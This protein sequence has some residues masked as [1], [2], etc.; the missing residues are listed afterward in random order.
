MSPRWKKLVND[1]RLAK[2]RLFLML[3]ALFV[4]IFG[5]SLIFSSYTI[6]TRELDLNYLK[7]NPASAMLEVENL[8]SSLIEEVRNQPGI[9]DAEPTSWVSARIETREK[10]WI[11]LQLFV[12]ED[13]ESLRINKFW[14]QSGDWPPPEGSLLLERT[15]L[16]LLKASEGDQLTVQTPNGS[17]REILVS[18]VVHDPALTPASQEQRAYG[19]ITPSTLEW[20]GEENSLN[21]LKVTMT[22]SSFDAEVIEKKAVNLAGWLQGQGYTVEEIRIPPPGKHP[23]QSQVTGIQLMLFTFSILTLILSA[24]L[25]ATMI[26]GLLARQVREIGI[27]KAIGAQTRQIALPYLIL[28]AGMGFIA[29]LLGG[30]LGIK[31]GRGFAQIIADQLNFTLYSQSVSE[32]TY[33]LLFGFGILVPLLTAMIPISE[34]ARITVREAINDYENSRK[35]F[36]FHKLDRLFAKLKGVDRTLL[37]SLRNPFRKKGRLVLTLSLLTAAGGLFLTSLN[38]QSSWNALLSEAASNRHYDLEVRTSHLVSE[39]KMVSMISN[40][41]GVEKVESWNISAAAV[42]R[43]DGLAVVHTYPDGSH[44]SF[45]VRSFPDDSK[46]VELPLLEGR[47]FQPEESNAIVLNHTARNFLPGVKPGDNIQLTI[48]GR[49]VILQ[50]SGIVKEIGPAIGYMSPATYD[51]VTGLSGQTNAVRVVMTEHSNAHRVSVKQE[52]QQA[53]ENE[54]IRLQSDITETE[55]DEAID[56]H[57][58]MLM[59]TFVM[60]AVLMAMVGVFGLMSVMGTNVIERTRE[61]GVMRAIGGKSGTILR[62]IIGEGVFIGMMSWILAVLLSLPLSKVVG[63]MIGHLM[64]QTALPQTVSMSAFIIW[65]MLIVVGSAAASAYPAWKASRLSIRETLHSI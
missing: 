38:I 61:F 57:V 28:V 42:S 34:A 27:M 63:S 51:Q 31:A 64:F 43:P 46:M 52:I 6:L 4:G 40:V 5:V 9:K 35:S 19:Y 36:G 44:G 16:P 58:F 3:M 49:P 13:F 50:V 14:P 26:K 18:G 55:L 48:E 29:V 59:M 32:W 17:K 24:I 47:W 56:S 8:D 41:P 7:T 10:K 12:L 37:L 65:F 60:M 25:I 1:I 11:P 20:L 23:H 22:P 21:I 33:P 39:E 54:G 62:N 15:A 2:G 30:P 53:L 45:T